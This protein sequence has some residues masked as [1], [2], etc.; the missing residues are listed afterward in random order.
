MIWTTVR[1]TARSK[2]GLE[3]IYIC[4]KID[5]GQRKGYS[6]LVLQSV[7]S[8]DGELVVDDDVELV[9]GV[10]SGGNHAFQ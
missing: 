9:D 3:V 6:R 2:E 5:W 7:Y 8:D 10:E 1:G 4:K